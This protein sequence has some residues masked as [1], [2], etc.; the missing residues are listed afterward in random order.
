MRERREAFTSRDEK[1][2]PGAAGAKSG[3]SGKH[4]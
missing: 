1:C 4:E 3:K 2:A